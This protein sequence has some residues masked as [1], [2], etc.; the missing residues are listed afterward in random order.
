MR[1][2]RGGRVACRSSRSPISVA[3]RFSWRTVRG[4]IRSLV[5]K[6]SDTAPRTAPSLVSTGAARQ[7][8]PSVV[9]SLSSA[10]PVCRT[11]SRMLRRTV[12]LI[13][14]PSGT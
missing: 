3:D 9:P 4:E 8:A 2:E 14:Y 13:Y 10:M 11:C 6:L 7:R 12:G 1:S 5:G